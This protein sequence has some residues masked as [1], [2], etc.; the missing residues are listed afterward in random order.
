[1]VIVLVTEPKV[2]G[3]KP[4][5]ERLIFKGGKTHST[6]TFGGEVKPEFPCRKV[7]LHVKVTSMNRNTSQGK[8]IIPLAPILP[9]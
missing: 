6:P 3:F 9:T 8:I 2:F 5:Q 7:L 4:G 1:M